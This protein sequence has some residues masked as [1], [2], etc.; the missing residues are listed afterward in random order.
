MAATQIANLYRLIDDYGSSNTSGAGTGAGSGQP[1]C[2]DFVAPTIAAA[3]QMA[4]ILCTCLQ[5]PARLVPVG[6]QPPYTLITGG[7]VNVA[8][9]SV[10]SGIQCP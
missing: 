8:L 9:T 7:A 2:P 4:F 5:R 3:A 10:P 1:L 6:G